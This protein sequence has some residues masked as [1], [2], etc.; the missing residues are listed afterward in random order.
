M[1]SKSTYSAIWLACIAIQILICSPV[2]RTGTSLGLFLAIPLVTLGLFVWKWD[3]VIRFPNHWGTLTLLCSGLGISALSTL[4][5]QTTLACFGLSLTMFAFFATHE[6]LQQHK[7]T[8]LG[9]LLF[10]ILAAPTLASDWIAAGSRASILSVA[11]NILRTLKTP[12]VLLDD[13]I[14]IP[15]QTLTIHDSAD[16]YLGW[17]AFAFIAVIYSL[18]LGRNWIIT[19][20][21]VVSACCC[22][23][24]FHC[25]ILVA[26]AVLR[27]NGAML[28]SISLF[29]LCILAVV[30]L[31]LSTERGLRGIF[32]PIED[33]SGDARNANP[34]IVTWNFLDAR[35]IAT[36]R[37]NRDRTTSM[38]L[39]TVGL[40]ALVALACQLGH[41]AGLL[42][43]GSTNARVNNARVTNDMTTSVKV[44]ES[45]D[46]DLDATL[47]VCIPGRV[48][49]D[50]LA[51]S[52]NCG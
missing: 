31:F 20:L 30:L 33:G 38:Q 43:S 6:D 7:L 13:A 21:N 4:I 36:G 24:V 50:C 40:F 51:R 26:T 8:H 22:W 14:K 35:K 25:G 34:L 47:F 17:Q 28:N 9:W 10:P 18:L 1:N 16:S 49:R 29:V 12:F 3:Q 46:V 44:E 37:K 5:G 11:G 2:I 52:V 27:N 15:T 23:F 41:F 45:R 19:F 39:I 42:G 48:D 32:A